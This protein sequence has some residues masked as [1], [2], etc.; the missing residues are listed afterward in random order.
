MDD[1]LEER[2]RAL[3]RTVTE[4]EYELSELTEE[5]AARERLDEIEA[6]TAELADRVAEL[7]AATQA[8]RGYVGNV[9]A[10][11]QDVEQR[12]DAALAK[13][14]SVEKRLE[15]S[16]ETPDSSAGGQRATASADG[17]VVTDERSGHSCAV[18]G[19]GPESDAASTAG[20]DRTPNPENSEDDGETLVPETTETGTLRRIRELL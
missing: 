4:G 18:C 5:A 12:A 17:G 3:E 14:E 15:R 9:R 10:V 11:N 2:V 20:L 6:E 7:E 8:L 1:T 19:R 13:A 16:H